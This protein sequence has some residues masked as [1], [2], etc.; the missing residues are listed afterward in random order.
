LDRGCAI[1]T[2]LQ[3]NQQDKM[4]IAERM[5]KDAEHELEEAKAYAQTAQLALQQKKQAV[6]I[7]FARL[8]ST[9]KATSHPSTPPHCTTGLNRTG[10]HTTPRHTTPHHIKL[11]HIISHHTTPRHVTLRHTTPHHTTSHYTTPRRIT[12]PFFVFVAA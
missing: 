10:R 4:V 5:I 11:Y 12:P 6:C 3:D 9:C 7:P 1:T 2:C 8:P